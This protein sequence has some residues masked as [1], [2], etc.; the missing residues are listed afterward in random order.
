ML[1]M[2]TK[3]IHM[4]NTQIIKT[5]EKMNE[6]LSVYMK[7]DPDIFTIASKLLPP[8]SSS[9]VFAIRIYA[10]LWEL[11]YQQGLVF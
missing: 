7:Y 4:Y 3:M 5:H 8:L 10:L 11:S 2:L 9:L 1:C 6:L